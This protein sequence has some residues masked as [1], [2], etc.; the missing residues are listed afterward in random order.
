MITK[1]QPELTAA[2]VKAFAKELGADLVGIAPI[3]RFADLPDAHNP[4]R[5]FPETRSVIVI[6]RRIPRGALRGV[7][8]GTQ[9]SLY[10]MYGY[11]WLDNRFLPMVTYGVAEFLE[12][13][14]YE[15]VPLPNL[16]PQMPA[17]G[18][19]ISPDRPAPNV[20]LDFDDAAVRAG[21]G[22]IDGAGF[23]I[24][25]EFGPHQRL[26][27]IL[28]EATLDPDAVRTTAVNDCP[29]AKYDAF[30]PLGALDTANK[31]V[32]WAQCRACKN[33][34]RANAYHPTGNPDRLAAICARSCLDYLEKHNRLQRKF[35]N[36][37]RQRPAWK[38]V[39]GQTYLEEGTEIE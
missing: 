32:D 3:E 6:G 12:N 24:T 4:A 20:L 38:I 31:T 10:A 21:L 35:A 39:D 14:G 7:E 9:F 25:P 11:D 34:A 22:E 26:Q 37:F 1:T 19:A 36:P 18:V 23:L 2:D 28:T 29:P 15:A 8:E 27:L 13:N 17:M 30:C 33:G 16:P 5:I